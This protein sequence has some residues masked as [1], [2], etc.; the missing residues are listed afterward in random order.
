M[1][2]VLGALTPLAIYD[3][4]ERRSLRQAQLDAFQT[5]WQDDAITIQHLFEL[6]ALSDAPD[7]VDQ[8]IHMTQSPL[9]Q[10]E[11]P[12]HI[13]A[14][15]GTFYS[16]NTRYFHDPSGRGYQ[17][18]T[19]F[20]IELD[21]LNPSSAVDLVP[22]LVDWKKF[23]PVRQEKMLEQLVRLY[24]LPDLSSAVRELVEK[25]MPDNLESIQS[26]LSYKS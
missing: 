25:A 15:L 13:H 17:L 2:D 26:K 10:K 3:K 24:E 5:K 21:E 16:Q 14:L 9:F 23:E 11:N 19:D 22:A 6:Y 12:K 8:I 18:I 4:P 7:A 1:T 20:I